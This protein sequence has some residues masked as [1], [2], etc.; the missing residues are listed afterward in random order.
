MKSDVLDKDNKGYRE[1]ASGEQQ[2]SD[3]PANTVGLAGNAAT[4]AVEHTAQWVRPK[5][6]ERYFRWKRRR[7]TWVPIVN[8][9]IGF[10]AFM[11]ILAQAIIYYQQRQIMNR[12]SEFMNKQTGIMQQSLDVSQQSLQAGEQSFRV[13]QRAYVGILNLTANLKAGEIL[14]V[15]QNIGHV[16]A[17]AIRLDGQA[18]KVTPSQSN[19]RTES[20]ERLNE[21][22]EGS[23]FHWTAGELQLFPGTPMTAAIHMQ[24]LQPDEVN[25][26]LEKKQFLYLGGTIQYEDGFG[27]R[28]S[29]IFAFQYNP[30][31]NEHWT[32]NSA[33]SRFFKPQ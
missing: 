29:T 1:K 27:A 28:D 12:Q 30:P 25:A 3:A 15:L 10:L 19:E 6:L 20:G 33:L 22:Q 7:E 11:V 4:P 31:P 23:E 18:I 13:T 2:P 5:L 24:T 32:A 21:S 26:L 14:I 17:K 9:V 16:P 8:V